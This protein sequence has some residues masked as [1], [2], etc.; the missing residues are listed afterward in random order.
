MDGKSERDVSA[1]FYAER[2]HPC[3]SFSAAADAE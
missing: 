2:R 1:T 3:R